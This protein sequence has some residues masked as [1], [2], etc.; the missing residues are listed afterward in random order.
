MNF[1]LRMQFILRLWP[2]DLWGS[3]L[4]RFALCTHAARSAAVSRFGLS[5]ELPDRRPFCF[6]AALPSQVFF[7][8][9]K[10]ITT[11]ILATRSLNF[12]LQIRASISFLVVILSAVCTSWFPLLSI[13][14][15][16]GYHI[17]ARGAD[18]YRT[19]ISNSASKIRW[20]R[21]SLADSALAP[22][23]HSFL[24]KAGPVSPSTC[25]PTAC[26]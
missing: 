23:S 13:T 22:R 5:A 4:V 17:P 16:S 3:A 11:A 19:T 2:A 7:G 9:A 20:R 10:P 8:P 25:L 15:S 6:W 26:R 12:C 1:R 24:S 14:V 21:S 18:V